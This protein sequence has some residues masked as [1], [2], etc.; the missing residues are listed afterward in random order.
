[1]RPIWQEGARNRKIWE[2]KVPGRGRANSKVLKMKV[3][4]PCERG[5]EIALW[6]KSSEQEGGRKG[7]DPESLPWPVHKLGHHPEP[8]GSIVGF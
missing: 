1:M 4:L 2:K 8:R 5:Q 6:L 7:L 3:N